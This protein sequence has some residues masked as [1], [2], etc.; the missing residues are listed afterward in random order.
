MHPKSPKWLQDILEA[1][2]LIQTATAGRALADYETDR[3]LRSAI[4]RKFEIIGEAL[5]RIRQNDPALA[6]RI[7][8]N[9]A[10]I[11]F[12]NLLIHGYDSIDHSRVWAVIQ[13]DAPQLQGLVA[14][15]L[16]EAGPPPMDG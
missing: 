13:K 9:R 3:V 2:D 7:P 5:N 15:L 4:E 14:Q 10:I 12:R 16:K 11:G 6:E 1:C 8:D